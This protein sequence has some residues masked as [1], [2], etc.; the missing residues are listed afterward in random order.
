MPV[1]PGYRHPQEAE[2]L[3]PV[4]S[5][6]SDAL[7]HCRPTSPISTI[8]TISTSRAREREREHIPYRRRVEEESR[9]SSRRHHEDEIRIHR[10]SD[11]AEFGQRRRG[12]VYERL[13]HRPE[14]RREES[15]LVP[16]HLMRCDRDRVDIADGTKD[17]K[18]EQ[19]TIEETPK[20]Q[21]LCP[22]Y[23]GT[24]NFYKHLIL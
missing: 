3:A 5:A 15:H 17:D 19:T 23:E 22:D 12:N 7:V 10:H 18:T 24:V 16:V 9:R 20:R 11:I 13:G 2:S 6:I 14:C 21:Q 4:A 1:G 8:S